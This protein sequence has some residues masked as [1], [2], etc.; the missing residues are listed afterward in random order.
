MHNGVVHPWGVYPCHI[1]LP[2]EHGQIYLDLLYIHY[3]ISEGSLT[4]WIP[5]VD[6]ALDR[7]FGIDGLFAV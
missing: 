7:Q 1:R 2:P 5:W 3:E 6:A 4:S